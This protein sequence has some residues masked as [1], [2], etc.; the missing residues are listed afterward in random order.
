[1]PF[2]LVFRKNHFSN[3]IKSSIRLWY[4][5]LENDLKLIHITNLLKHMCSSPLYH[6]KYR[7]VSVLHARLRNKCSTLNNALF[8]NHIRDNPLYMTCV[9]WSRTPST[10]FFHFRKFTIERQDFNETVLILG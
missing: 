5:N 4:L 2:T 1:M 6:R 9:S 10:T 8:R 3:F 7:Y